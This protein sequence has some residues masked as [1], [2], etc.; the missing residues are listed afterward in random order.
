VSVPISSASRPSFLIPVSIDRPGD[1]PIFALDREARA[2]AAAG[3]DVLNA[4]LGALMEDDGRLAV[5]P[6]VRVALERVDPV[7]AAGY[8]PIAGEPRFLE[9]VRADLFGDGA[10]AG[11]SVAVATPGGTGAV[12]HA[13]VNFLDLDQALLTTSYYWG[14]YKTLAEHTRRRIATF[15]MFDGGGRLD[16]EALEAAVERQAAEQ[17]R[18]LLVLNTPCHNPT[19][20]SL[21]EGEW[22]ALTRILKARAERAPIAL[23][24]D[25]AYAHFGARGSGAWVRH[26]EQLAG[27]VLVLCAWTISKAFTQ[28]GARVG[29]L[30]AVHPDATERKRLLNALAYSCRGTWSNCNHLGML[31]IGALLDDPELR[32]RS[33]RERDRLRALL[34]ERVAAFK[35]AAGAAGLA[36][37]RYEGGFF[38]TVFTRNSEV[39][40]RTMR[41]L[42][43]FVVPLPG[44]VRVAL[45][46]T[47]VGRVQRLVD[48]LVAGVRAAGG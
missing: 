21:D 25:L 39:C 24:L 32:A 10:L 42:G 4:T 15:R 33:L 38:V 44:A 48:A 13:I 30:V 45:C 28:Y 7:R 14:P 6:S 11:Q 1:D 17:G 29:A 34:G 20:Y 16:L 12:H 22:Q 5:M 46:S 3:E 19:G 26:A 36:F 2:R 31:T 27:H 35:A 43:A 47:P 37:P 8:A 18:V 9:A 41:D 23:L 40:A